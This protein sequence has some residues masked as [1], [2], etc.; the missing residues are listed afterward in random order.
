MT[1]EKRPPVNNGH[2][3]WVRRMVVVYRFDSTNKNW[4]GKGQKCELTNLLN[5]RI[6]KQVKYRD[7]NFCQAVKKP[8]RLFPIFAS[9]GALHPPH[10]SVF[11]K[12]FHWSYLND[13]TD[14]GTWGQGN[15]PKLRD[16]IYEG[17][18]SRVSNPTF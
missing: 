13:V 12:N 8:I 9:F 7:S 5:T 1:S 3:F 6:D 2:Y 16:V 14:V 15:C 17:P 10:C 18:G 4:V 11:S